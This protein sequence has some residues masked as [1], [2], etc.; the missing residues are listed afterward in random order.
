MK[1]V[2]ITE[3]NLELKKEEK[4]IGANLAEDAKL[5][6]LWKLLQLSL[7]KNYT[8]LPKRILNISNYLTDQQQTNYAA[9]LKYINNTLDAMT[10]QI[11]S[12]MG[13]T[14]F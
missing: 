3:E 7:K 11:K 10:F 13:G 5:K 4:L 9:V 14:K 1:K 6:K 12:D 2:L 8:L